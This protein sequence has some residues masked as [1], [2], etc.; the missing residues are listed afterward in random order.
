MILLRFRLKRSPLHSL[1]INLIVLHTAGVV[2]NSNIMFS[3]NRKAFPAP[4]SKS[5]NILQH[6]ELFSPSVPP[7]DGAVNLGRI[8]IGASICHSEKMLNHIVINYK[9]IRNNLYIFLP[10]MMK[11]CTFYN[12]NNNNGNG[13]LKK[14][15]GVED[16]VFSISKN[17]SFC[18]KIVEFRA[19]GSANNNYTLYPKW[20]RHRSASAQSFEGEQHASAH[21]EPA[22]QK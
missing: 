10:V 2:S 4:S 6:S 16:S 1:T 12:N 20:K 3:I 9:L 11:F 5:R 17:Q 21:R 15:F 8:L 14:I 18:H 22:Y 19:S 7:V 13:K